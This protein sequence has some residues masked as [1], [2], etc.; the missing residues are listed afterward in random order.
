[1]QEIQALF[2]RLQRSTLNLHS[3]LFSVLPAVSFQLPSDLTQKKHFQGIQD[4][5]V[6]EPTEALRSKERFPIILIT[7]VTSCL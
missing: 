3:G 6:A 1:M 2:V 5:D 7:F 4:A